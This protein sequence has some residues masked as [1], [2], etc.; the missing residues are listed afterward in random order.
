M[1]R[2]GKYWTK[3]QG[4]M[5]HLFQEMQLS[6]AAGIVPIFRL[7]EVMKSKISGCDEAKHS[8]SDTLTMFS[9][10]LSGKH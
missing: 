10:L 3:G 2:Y 6:L 8:I 9:D 7:V 4:L 1:V 5:K